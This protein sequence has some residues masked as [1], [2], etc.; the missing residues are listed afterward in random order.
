MNL[1]EDLEAYI[2]LISK[3]MEQKEKEMEN[4]EKSKK[5]KV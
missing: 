4:K 3:K 1:I 5:K 2:M